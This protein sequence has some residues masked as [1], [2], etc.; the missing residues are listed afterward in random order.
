MELWK[1]S[2]NLLVFI[3]IL[4]I[5]LYNSKLFRYFECEDKFG[6]FTPIAKVSK[7]PM[8]ANRMSSNC[9]IH[10]SKRSPDSM[11]GSMISAI[12][13]NTMSSIPTRVRLGV[14]SLSYKVFC[15]HFNSF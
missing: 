11:N 3:K 15:M 13:S 8:S 12:T 4:L 7:S 9:A 2:S 5:Y 1:A 10:K 14:A 6:L